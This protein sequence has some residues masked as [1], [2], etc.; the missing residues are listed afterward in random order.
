M[1]A[2]SQLVKES[3]KEKPFWVKVLASTQSLGS[4]RTARNKG[5][6]K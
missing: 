6:Y 5:P 2:M 3:V 1:S 4:H